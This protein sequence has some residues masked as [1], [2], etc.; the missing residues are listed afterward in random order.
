MTAAVS[1]WRATARFTLTT[2]PSR[3]TLLLI[4]AAACIINLVLS[5]LPITVATLAVLTETRL[6]I[7]AAVCTALLAHSDSAMAVQ[8]LETR[9]L[10]AAV[11]IKSAARLTSSTAQWRATQHL[12][13]GA[14]CMLLVATSNSKAVKSAAL[15][16]LMPTRLLMA[17][18]SSLQMESRLLYTVAA[19]ALFHITLQQARAAAL[20][21]A[22]ETPS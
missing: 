11:C 13:T 19:K 22:A 17:L 8:F 20:R 6:A 2:V 14:P 15:Q 7:T 4:T 18:V 12:E 5:A 3:T 16:T 1:T 10:T 21:L 9:L